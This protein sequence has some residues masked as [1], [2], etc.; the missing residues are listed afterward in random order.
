MKVCT[1]S[2][3]RSRVHSYFTELNKW[4]L[5]RVEEGLYNYYRD[6]NNKSLHT[7]EASTD[8]NIVVLGMFIDDELTSWSHLRNNINDYVKNNIS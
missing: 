6:Q 2:S 4:T 8:N 3:P 7:R 5:E 1:T